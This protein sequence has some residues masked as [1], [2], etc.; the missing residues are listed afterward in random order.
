MIWEVNKKR[1]NHMNAI[2]K[3]Y[4]DGSEILQSWNTDVVKKTPDGKYIRL[5][6]GWSSSTMK[7][8]KAY[9][10]LY[11]RGIPFADGHVEDTSKKYYRKGF[12]IMHNAVQEHT[13]EYCHTLSQ[14]II[15]AINDK[16]ISRLAVSYASSCRKELTPFVKNHSKY[17]DL[18]DSMYMCANQVSVKSKLGVLC[19]LYNYNFKE[20][21]NSALKEQYADFQGEPL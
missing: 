3:Y 15:S 10:G 11:F 12:D 8:V 16:D 9:C 21:W 4:N 7:Q 13:A 18:L 5:W 19:R 14:V 2:I 17:K 20:L 1:L 6:T